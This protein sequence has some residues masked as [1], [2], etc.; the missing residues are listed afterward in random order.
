MAGITAD[1]EC[2]RWCSPGGASKPAR[3]EK[4]HSSSSGSSDTESKQT[5][6][7]LGAHPCDIL[8][9]VSALQLPVYLVHCLCNAIACTC[10]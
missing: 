2:F 3:V 9:T 8:E 10:G 6:Q 1:A 5:D 4:A 7:I